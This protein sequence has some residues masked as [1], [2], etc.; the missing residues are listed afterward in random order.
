LQ[1]EGGSPN[2]EFERKVWR[3]SQGVGVPKTKVCD[4][5]RRRC[6]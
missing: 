3:Q 5:S 4:D 1:A 2:Y 6:G